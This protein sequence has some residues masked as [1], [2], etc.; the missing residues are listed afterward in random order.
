MIQNK[1]LFVHVSVV[2]IFLMMM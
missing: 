1:S 2:N